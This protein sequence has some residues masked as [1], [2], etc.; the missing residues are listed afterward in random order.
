MSHRTAKRPEQLSRKNEIPNSA[1][2]HQSEPLFSGSFQFEILPKE[3]RRRDLL[4][5]QSLAGSGF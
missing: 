4:I 1:D 3:S 2:E 5:L